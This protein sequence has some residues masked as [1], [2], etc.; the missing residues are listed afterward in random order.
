MRVYGITEQQKLFV[1][2]YL[3]LRKQNGKQAALN[4]G[5]SE[6]TAQVQASQLLNKTNV[7]EYLKEREKYL[8]DELRSEFF[9]DALEARKEM[10]KIMKSEATSPRDKITV[11]MDFLDRAGFKSTNKV[12]VNAEIKGTITTKNPFEGLTKEELL[13]IASEGNE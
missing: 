2:E 5:Y 10:Y 6:K 12:E 1:D 3:K 8:E 4:A 9:F 13:K 11:A 7:K